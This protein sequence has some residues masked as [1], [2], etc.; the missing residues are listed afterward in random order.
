MWTNSR[1]FFGRRFGY[2]NCSATLTMKKR[3]SRSQ[4]KEIG[5]T[6]H[7]HMLKTLGASK[8]GRP[9]KSSNRRRDYNREQAYVTVSS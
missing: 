5:T 9:E 8:S 4:G 1:L 3:D 7:V 6:R 2:T